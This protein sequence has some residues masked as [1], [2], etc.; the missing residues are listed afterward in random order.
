MYVLNFDSSNQKFKSGIIPQSNQTVVP[1]IISNFDLKLYPLSWT[2]E[3]ESIGVT[4]FHRLVSAFIE[5]A[6]PHHVEMAQKG[7]SQ[8]KGEQRQKAAATMKKTARAPPPPLCST[9]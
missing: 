2:M 7:K 9:T 3:V 8:S 5:S 6:L 4:R 1:K